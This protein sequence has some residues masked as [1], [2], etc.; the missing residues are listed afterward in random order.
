MSTV[1]KPS[2]E[3][4]G[5]PRGLPSPVSGVVYELS[6]LANGVRVAT[7]EMPHMASVSLGLWAAVGS[8]HETDAEHGAAHFIEH[9]L[10]KGTPARSASAIAREIEGI[11]GSLD[12][13]TSEDHTCYYSKG[14]ADM[15]GPM[16]D[17]LV[18]MYQ[19]PSLKPAD[20]DNERSVINEEIAMV[21]DQPSQ[22]LD[23]ILSA[24]AWG[25]NHPLGRSIAGTVESLARLDRTRL[26]SFFNRTYTG[27]QTVVT[28]AGAITHQ[29]VL[30]EIGPR[31]E[32]MP[33]GQ[34]LPIQGPR[35]Q[36]G[37]KGFGLATMDTEQVHFSVAFLAHDRHREERYTQKLLC[38][39]LGENMS[40]LL[41]QK[42]REEEAVCYCIQSDVTLLEDAGLLHIYCAL[43][44]EH[45]ARALQIFTRILDELKRKPPSQAKLEEAKG[46]VVGQ[47]RI[48]LENTGAQMTWLGE[49][50][51]AY[52]RLIDPLDSQL[53]IQAVG[54]EDI[55][56]MANTLF[57]PQRLV[58]AAVGPD[59][60]EVPLRQWQRDFSS[61]NK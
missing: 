5:Y 7:A 35:L 44:P 56:R 47:S 20:I 4:A 52:G 46:Y 36:T 42:L 38:V 2:I 37:D 17:V 10:F 34:P 28:A 43:D 21:H 50:I 18:D 30:E 41:F 45:L 8:R 26:Q 29:Q 59:G 33:A 58:V 1:L 57:D 14:P 16:A 3:K 32:A 51:M 22:Y 48:A 9:L 24:A 19:H 27:H 25:G 53:R 15:F 54:P 31:L 55:Q 49:S 40:S 60:V 13:Y 6:E 11:G 61:E 39:L 12:A 23:D